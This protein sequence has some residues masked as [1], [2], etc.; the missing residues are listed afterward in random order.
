LGCAFAAAFPDFDLLFSSHRTYTHSI[1]AVV[2]FGVVAWFVFRGQVPLPPWRTRAAVTLAAAYASH[3]LLDWLGKDSATPAGL[4]ALWPLSS[5]F[6]QS[7]LDLFQEVSRRYW[8]ADEFIL[9]NLGAVGWEVLILGPIA[10]VA[11]WI[12]RRFMV[13]GQ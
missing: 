1:A 3:L 2:M 5:R 4:M 7:G 11:W 13:D 12:H 8:N 10:G 9:G 6:Y